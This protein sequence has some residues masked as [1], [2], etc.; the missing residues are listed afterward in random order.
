MASPSTS[1]S[2]AEYWIQCLTRAWLDNFVWLDSTRLETP[3]TRDLTRLEHWSQWLVT[4][5][6]LDPHDSWLDSGLVPSDSSTA[7]IR[8]HLCLALDTMPP[9]WLLKFSLGSI[10][11]LRPVTYSETVMWEDEIENVGRILWWPRKSILHLVWDIF[12]CHVKDHSWM[13]SRW[14]W[15]WVGWI[16]VLNSV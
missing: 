2:N 9:I 16:F 7:L 10:V 5:L 15:S 4:R 1:K 11:T 8:A 13:R 3:V 14:V 12:S 6:G